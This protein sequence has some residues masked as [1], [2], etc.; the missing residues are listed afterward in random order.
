MIILNRFVDRNRE[1]KP[2][3]GKSV[4]VCTY[5]TTATAK[6]I[7]SLASLGARVTYV[8]VSRGSG[9]AAGRLGSVEN[10]TLLE[11]VEE[12]AC[13]ALPGADVILEESMRISEFVYR[14]PA[15]HRWKD[16]LYSIEQTTSGIRGFERAAE[17]GLLYP[18][19]NLAESGMKVDV[20][21]SAATPESILALLV[22]RESTALTL[23]N[24]LVMGYGSV[25]R[26]VA[27][28]CRSHGSV[29]TVSETDPVRRVVAMSH[30]YA[31]VDA[32]D[33]DAAIR[34]QDIVVSCTQN[35]NGESI[36]LDRIMLMRNGAMVVNA[37]TGTGEVSREALRPGTYERNR[38]IISV[39]EDDGCIVCSFE[40]MGMRK[41]V[42]ILCSAAPLNLGCG[43]GTADE[44][45]D[46]VFSLALSTI[47]SADGRRLSRSIHP[48]SRDAED[49]VAAVM[50][51]SRYG[52]RPVHIRGKELAP[53]KRPWGGLSRFA[54]VGDAPAITRFSTVRASFDPGTA[55]SGHYHTVS[56]EAYIAESG[57]ASITVWDPRDPGAG[58]KT[59]GVV[60]GDYLSIPRGMAHR[61]LADAVDG[62][63]CIVVA[64]PPFSFW[65]QFF[66]ERPA[67]NANKP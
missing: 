41:N 15:R 43:S 37:G 1:L 34:D 46:I 51:P 6:L 22:S 58:S 14:D 53:E 26:G 19:V 40:K 17:A 47:M 10:V 7:E 8:P 67:G 49:M 64:S 35:S 27:R 42:R 28:L 56:E 39:T 3:A 25:G 31:T 33:I 20:E 66:P 38:A 50:L 63:V 61:V 30:G 32:R 4:L 57:G 11:S 48:V 23:K 65:D 21:N 55:T 62:F 59:Y 12:A 60:S 24:V 54:P 18:V 9:P 36:G 5:D 44:I 13:E 29:V 16:S 52:A 45:I 2:L